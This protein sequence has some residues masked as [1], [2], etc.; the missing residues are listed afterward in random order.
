MSNQ[1][2]YDPQQPW[3]QPPG[4]PPPATPQPGYQSPG[5]PAQPEYQQPG[6]Q[7]PG[8]QQP[9][10]QQPGYPAPGSP[11]P[12]S[13]APAQPGY[14]PSYQ[15]PSGY[16]SGQPGYPEPATYQQPAYQQPYDPNYQQYG[17]PAPPPKKSKRWLWISL[18]VAGVLL[19]VCGVGGFLLFRNTLN[20]ATETL[21]TPAEVHG[22]T[23]TTDAN[24]TQLAE[25]A[26]TDLRQQVKNSTGSI[27]AFYSDPS[28]PTKLTMVVG[29][30]GTVANPKN[31]IK[32]A[33]DQLN[34]SGLSAGDV[35][36]VDSGSLGG[37]TRCGT[38]SASGQDL[39][40]CVWAD[41]GSVGM[42]V[43][44]NRPVA[45]SESLFSEFRT[46]IIKR[47]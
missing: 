14:Q 23:L 24:L 29:V 26:K 12:G 1:N 2:P 44:F 47:D 39:V 42:M 7:Q 16:P 27:G 21:V 41:H 19:V 35:H 31:E 37:E 28:D 8:Y 15:P 32:D 43:F 20:E 22:L 11:A 6:Y 9:G 10:Y 38:G 17:V 45:E 4:S 36:D 40:V 25:Q 3:G 34:T 46:A 13:P 18:A 30:S 5:Y 33:F